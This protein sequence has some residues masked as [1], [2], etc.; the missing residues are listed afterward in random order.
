MWFWEMIELIKE[1]LKNSV[2]QELYR[3]RDNLVKIETFNLNYYYKI[4][5]IGGKGALEGVAARVRG[6]CG[7]W[8]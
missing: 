4:G 3:N 2:P 1:G 8:K 7:F 6:V 5:K